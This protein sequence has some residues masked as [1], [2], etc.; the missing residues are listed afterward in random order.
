MKCLINLGAVDKVITFALNARQAQ[1]Y[2]LAGN[3]LQT[4]DWH[5]NPDLIRHIITFYTRAKANDHLAGYVLIYI[6]IKV[7]VSIY[8]FSINRILFI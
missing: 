7:Y 6:Y 1:I 8:L 5:K 3:F 2:V 4:T